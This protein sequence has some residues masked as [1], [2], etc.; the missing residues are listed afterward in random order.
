MSSP[1]LPGRFA[2][3]DVHDPPM[4]QHRCG[5]RSVEYA[6]GQHVEPQGLRR[7]AEHRWENIGK[8]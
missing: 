6:A 8:I 2:G 4:G 3:G 5:L 1:A 7:F